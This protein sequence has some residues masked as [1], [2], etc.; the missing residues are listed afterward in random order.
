MV[1]SEDPQIVADG[2][3]ITFAAEALRGGEQRART[4]RVAVW[5]R[6]GRGVRVHSRGPRER[7]AALFLLFRTEWAECAFSSTRPVL[8]PTPTRDRSNVRLSRPSTS[9]GAREYR[10]VR[11]TTKS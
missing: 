8:V 2:A 9:W 4:V 6:R 1:S 7:H 10:Y 5:R 11:H 3:K